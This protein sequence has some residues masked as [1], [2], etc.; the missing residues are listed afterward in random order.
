M[1]WFFGFLPLVLSSPGA[2]DTTGLR[3]RRSLGRLVQSAAPNS[4]HLKLNHDYTY[5]SA[6][7][8][9]RNYVFSNVACPTHPGSI[10]VL[11]F[12]K[13]RLRQ[14]PQRVKCSRKS[15]TNTCTKIYN[16]SDYPHIQYPQIEHV[17]ERFGP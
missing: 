3:W 6:P 4:D 17:F 7:P 11:F 1:V 9:R 5:P 13:K 10:I 2:P 8:I 12:P 14:Y 16:I 15:L